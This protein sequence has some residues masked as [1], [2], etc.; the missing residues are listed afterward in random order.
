[1]GVEA[2]QRRGPWR[3]LL[4]ALL[5]VVSWLALAPLA[6][7]DGGL[8]L[9]KG[10]HL[11]AFAVLAWVAAQGFARD[12]AGAWRIAAA[13]LAY[14]VA[15]EF[16]QAHVPGRTASVGDAVADALGIALGLWVARR[17]SVAR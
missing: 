6:F 3:A 2:L 1:V 13:L 9:D 5:A 4:L 11:A 15:I 7:N 10:R 8:P 12:R 17:F 14:G 16:V